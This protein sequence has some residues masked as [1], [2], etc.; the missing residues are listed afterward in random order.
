MQRAPAPSSRE[1]QYQVLSSTQVFQMGPWDH[2]FP[3]PVVLMGLT[4]PEPRSSVGYA[5]HR[6]IEQSR[7]ATGL[8]VQPA[9]PG[10]TSPALKPGL[11]G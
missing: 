3:Q 4:A 8:C 11:C 1:T 7:T 9:S 10:L 6:L 5:V 2:G